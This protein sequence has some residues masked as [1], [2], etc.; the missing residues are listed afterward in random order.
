MAETFLA[1]LQPEADSSSEAG[2]P[3]PEGPGALP[4]RSLSGDQLPPLSARSYEFVKAKLQAELLKVRIWAQD[5]GQKFVV[6]LE[7]RDAAGKGG[8]IK[9]FMEHL[10]PRY[11]RFVAM[12]KPNEREKGHWFF[13]RYVA[14][15]PTAG[16]MVLYDRSWY[17]RVGVERAMGFCRPEEHLEF[18]HEAPELERT[19]VR[20]GIR[21]AK[22]W[23][24]VTREEQRRRFIAR[25]TDPLK[26]WKLSPVDKASLD[27]WDGYSEAKEAIL[28]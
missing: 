14:H 27:R 12:T 15:L 10:S 9:R 25:E 4:A 3:L 5:S 17:N 22:Y 16:E 7:G 13:Q 21:V 1:T 26:R 11:A 8:T 28:F 19:L 20:S 18:M 6:L 2:A 23:F 24:S